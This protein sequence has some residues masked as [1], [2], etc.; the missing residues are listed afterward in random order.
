MNSERSAG[1]GQFALE[2]FH[3]GE[4]FVLPSGIRGC[5][6]AEDPKGDYVG[7]WLD[8]GTDH[9]HR[10]AIWRKRLVSA[11]S[12]E[13]ARVVEARSTAMKG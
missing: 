1:Y 6:C 2:Y 9:A 13:Q 4:L 7:V 8:F 5:V 10:T 11:S 12:A 3:S